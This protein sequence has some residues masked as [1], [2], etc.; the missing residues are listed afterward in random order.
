MRNKEGRIPALPVCGRDG[1]RDLI[2]RVRCSGWVT[3]ARVSCRLLDA[4]ELVGPVPVAYWTTAAPSAVDRP[5]T[6]TL[7]RCCARPPQCGPRG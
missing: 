4:D 1:T 7:C 2:S 3:W 5:V 6:S